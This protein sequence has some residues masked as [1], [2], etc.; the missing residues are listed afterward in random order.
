MLKLILFFILSFHQVFSLEIYL[1]KYGESN[2]PARLLNSSPARGDRPQIIWNFYLL[3]FGTRNVLIDTGTDDKLMIQRFGIQKFKSPKNLLKELKI[4]V[5]QITDVI[6]THSHFDHIGTVQDFKNAVIYINKTEYDDFKKKLEYQKQKSFFLEKEKKS[7]INFLSEIDLENY[8]FVFHD[9]Q[10]HTIGSRVIELKTNNRN[11]L[12]TGDECYYL[13]ECKEGIGLK[14][15]AA[16]NPKK[17]DLFVKELSKKFLN[18]FLLS[19][20]DPEIDQKFFQIQK[21]IFLLK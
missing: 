1:L 9:I 10:G 8:K 12:F 16:I 18:H 2:Y 7:E 20:H 11:Y 19:L 4:D 6:I 14:A 17:N 5:D 13:K 21:E 15:Q 3:K